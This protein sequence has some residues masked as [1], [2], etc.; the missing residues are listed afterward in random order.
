MAHRPYPNRDR[1]LAQV[2]R[3]APPVPGVQM[4]ERLRPMAKS[5]ARLRENTRQAAEQ[6][7][8]LDEYRLSTR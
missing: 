3:H 8:G 4:P 2:Y 5:F 1:A 7:F 6:G